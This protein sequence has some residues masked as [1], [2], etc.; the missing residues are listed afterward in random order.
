MGETRQYQAKT[1]EVALSKAARD[2]RV[3]MEAVQHEVVF[4]GR[5]GL[6]GFGQRD[7]IIRVDVDSSR[8]AAA[9]T[10]IAQERRDGAPS[11]AGGRRQ[12]A[13]PPPPPSAAPPRT[14]PA[15]RRGP[16]PPPHAPKGTT[17]G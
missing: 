5:R 9:E 8:S 7:V 13:P 12:G 15:P 1:L 16:P 10:G 14:R 4:D 6:F 3:P 2:L 17:H 11:G